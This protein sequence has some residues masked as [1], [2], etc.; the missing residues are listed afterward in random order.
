[1]RGEIR[2]RCLLAREALSGQEVAHLSALLVANLLRA[3]PCPPGKCV[4]FCWPVRNEADVRPAIHAWLKMGITAALPVTTMRGQPLIFRLWQ[5]E[6]PLAPDCKGISAPLD[7]APE[8]TPDTLLIPLNAF[9]AAGYRLGYGSGFF[10]RT[11]T[12][13][14][15][16]SVRPLAIGIGFELG[17]VADAHPDAHDQPMDWLI[18][19]AGVWQARKGCRKAG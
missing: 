19:E 11:L 4:G 3:F 17:R 18:T 7:D 8:V 13:L 10:D 14:A 12:A 9:D 1:M 15:A 16:R 2:K 6:A 5:A